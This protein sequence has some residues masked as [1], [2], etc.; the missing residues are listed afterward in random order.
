MAEWS[1]SI[2]KSAPKYLRGAVDATLKKRLIWA[3]CKAKGRI[4]TGHSSHTLY[5]QAEAEEIPVQTYGDFGVLD[6][7]SHDTHRQYNIDWKGYA[8]TS[9][10]TIKQQLMNEGDTKLIA[11]QVANGIPKLTKSVLHHLHSEFYQD[12]TSNANRFNGLEAFLGSGTTVVGDILAEPSD[13]YAGHSTALGVD[14]SWS[15]ALSTYPNTNV[16]SDWPK[17][18]GDPEYH[19]NSP[20]LWNW[21]S[22]TWT[23]TNTWASTCETVIR[24]ALTYNHLMSGAVGEP[25]SQ[26]IVMDGQMFNTLRDSFGADRRYLVQHKPS[27]DLG[28]GEVLS[29]DGAGLY[30]DYGVPANTFY[31]FNWEGMEVAMLGRN[32][33]KVMTGLK[34]PRRWADLYAVGVFGNFKWLPKCF[35]KGYNYAAS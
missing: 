20:Q 28:F 3:M 19:W 22:T 24:N 7:E 35:F 4:K 6:Y 25:G 27:A 5:W 17:G 21:A 32:V 9:A 33:L 30:F 10:I 13:T 12:G 29:Y 15:S 34:D 2:L 16:A 23:G 11:E 1:G 8:A 18:T 31:G 26:F 14:G